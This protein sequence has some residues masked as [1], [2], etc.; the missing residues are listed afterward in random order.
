MMFLT[1]RIGVFMKKL[2]TV[3]GILVMS[4]LFTDRV[5]AAE[6]QTV[7]KSQLTFIYINGSNDYSGADRLKFKDHFTKQVKGLHPYMVK[8]FNEDKLIQK[9][10]L[11]NGKIV[12][13]EEPIVFYWGDKS[14]DQVKQL[15]DDLDLTKTFSPRVAQIVRSTFARCMH[16]AV[17]V[18][19][20]Q[21][22]SVLIDELQAVVKS[23]QDKGNQVILLGYSAGSFITYE[24]FLNKFISIFPSE[25]QSDT[26]NKA[27]N[28]IIAKYPAQKT[29]L[30]ALM[31]ADI[32][33]LDLY[34]RYSLNPDTSIVV[35]QYPQLDKYTKSAC[36]DN[37]TV[38]GVVNF[39]SPLG[40]FYSEVKDSKS[41]INYLSKLMYKHILETDIFWL[42]VNYRED[43]LGIPASRNVTKDELQALSLGTIKFNRGFVYDKSD[44]ISRRTFISAH[45]AYW[46][47]QK[48]FAKAVVQAYNDGYLNMYP[49]SVDAEDL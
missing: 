36:F 22:M 34:G 40:L 42:T 26:S 16:D 46:D 27:V 6:L 35:K 43:P 15:N 7:P 3:A 21:N 19:K 4:L 49:E 13:N 24:Y 30:D 12:V 17:W 23:E 20:Y 1:N 11:K 25:M 37:G 47:T 14:L 31:E 33:R 32:M 39:A 2:L 45:L 28:D 44:I 9:N 38:K 8:A 18:Q 10:L 48:R 41:D 29:C 5:I